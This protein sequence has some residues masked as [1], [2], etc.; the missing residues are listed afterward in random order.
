MGDNQFLE[1]EPVTLSDNTVV[2]VP[3]TIE[4]DNVT[5]GNQDDVFTSAPPVSCVS[6]TED[7]PEVMSPVFM[8]DTGCGTEQNGVSSVLHSP[9]C[10]I[11]MDVPAPFTAIPTT[12]PQQNDCQS[13]L[14]EYN[15][16]LELFRQLPGDLFVSR[17]LK[18]YGSC[19]SDLD[20]TRYIL[21]ESLRESEDFPYPVM[22]DLKKR[23]YTRKGEPLC[24][25]LAHDIRTLLAVIEGDDY[26]VMKDLISSSRRKSLIK[27][28]GT[29]K[30]PAIN[31]TCSQDV[32][33]LQDSVS[34]LKSEIL[35][36]KQC[37]K[38]ND[39][40]RSTQIKTMSD[41]I[42][43]VKA[44]IKEC[45][46][47][48]ANSAAKIDNCI[49]LANNSETESVRSE[50][51]QLRLVLESVQRSLNVND[52]VPADVND[53][54]S[55]A[56]VPDCMFNTAGECESVTSMDHSLRSIKLPLAVDAPVNNDCQSKTSSYR[57]PVN[58]SAS[59][60]VGREIL[61]PATIPVICDGKLTYNS[62]LLYIH[63]Q[64][65]GQGQDCSQ[66]DTYANVL[67]N[68]SRQTN[69]SSKNKLRRRPKPNRRVVRFN[70]N[71][72]MNQYPPE[73]QNSAFRS[74]HN[75]SINVPP[76]EDFS[77]YVRKR[78]HRYYIGGFNSEMNST[79]IHN[80]VSRR[81]PKVTKVNIFPSR[82]ARDEVT[83]Q[84]NVEANSQ[85]SL[86]EQRE[87][88]PRGIVCKPWLTPR[89]QNRQRRPPRKDVPPR[90]SHNP[91]LWSDLWSET[92]PD[93]H[94]ANRYQGLDLE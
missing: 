88:W 13:H 91:S 34:T 67:T 26:S 17:I 24:V 36:L 25:K 71:P 79:K 66:N 64:P 43:M 19:E 85:S 16:L 14:I 80:Y 42:S 37:F 57:D 59:Q 94:S 2:K 23:V 51:I 45:S 77:V 18:D 63:D 1:M 87:F 48:I 52:Q 28:E 8:P 82:S 29:D 62:Q 39:S 20:Q 49:L 46:D 90:F 30:L 65:I 47:Y 54:H 27:I 69:S 84:L 10:I 89:E 33:I 58:V 6:T 50:I 5:T 41:T 15:R 21:Y 72:N 92:S 86:I 44:D 4:S 68:P 83:I 55:P 93:L 70:D 75:D 3:Y 12:I 76:E 56:D 7:N 73:G 38:A 60:A 31:C 74:D 11:E 40:M 78:T 22:S 9:S 35:M 61:Q 81:G 53:T 32:A